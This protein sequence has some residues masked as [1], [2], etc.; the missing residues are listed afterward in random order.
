VFEFRIDFDREVAIL[1]ATR[2]E[3]PYRATAISLGRTN[4]VTSLKG[5]PFVYIEYGSKVVVFDLLSVLLEGVIPCR[6]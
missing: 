1:G 6:V 4:R 5:E 2:E 3:T